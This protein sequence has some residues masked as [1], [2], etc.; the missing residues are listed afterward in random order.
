MMREKFESLRY[1]VLKKSSA[2]SVLDEFGAQVAIQTL[3]GLIESRHDNIYSIIPE[4]RRKPDWFCDAR[5]AAT[6]AKSARF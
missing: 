3:S 6:H 5:A 2:R 4:R 1:K